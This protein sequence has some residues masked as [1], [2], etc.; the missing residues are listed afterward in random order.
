MKQEFTSSEGAMEIANQFAQTLKY[1]Q[2]TEIKI[3]KGQSDSKK[4]KSK[5]KEN[6]SETIYQIT[7]FLELN[8]Q[9]INELKKR[10]GRF[11]LAT[12][13]LNKSQFSSDDIL[14]KYKEQQAPERSFGFLKDPLFFADS[15]FLKSPERIETMAMLMGL[16]LLVY[17]RLTTTT[18][19]LF[20]RSKN[21]TKKSTWEI[22]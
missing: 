20:K 4:K 11:V 7:T 14:T 8:H 5:K 12:N 21:W 13:R 15:V 22:N 18:S 1:H 10:A 2:M 6:Q 3:S 19:S 9:K 16:C 17:S